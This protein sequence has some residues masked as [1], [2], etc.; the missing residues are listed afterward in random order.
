MKV[1][2]LHGLRFGRLSVKSRSEN[3]K[4]GQARWVC[5]CDCGKETIVYGSSLR[6]NKT[7]SCGCTN[8][9]RIGDMNRTH[10]KTGTREYN[11]WRGMKRRCN[12]PKDSHYYLYGDR[13]I[14]YVVEWESFDRFY[15]D[16]GDCP[17]GFQLDR[18]DV[19]LGYSKDNCRWVDKTTQAFNIR[20]KSSNKSGRAGVFIK[21]GKFYVRITVYKKVIFLGVFL[22]FNDACIARANAELKYYGVVKE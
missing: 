5:V 19:N 11:S 15:S 10:S 21:D 7:Q 1:I 9:E 20:L 18:I 3:S 14:S 22:N 16:M 17:D 2:D 8:V 4:K 12:S 13:G 6:S